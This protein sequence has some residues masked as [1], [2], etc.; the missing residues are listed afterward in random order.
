MIKT[1]KTT[2]KPAKVSKPQVQ[3]TPKPKVSSKKTTPLKDVAKIV[4]KTGVSSAQT[5]TQKK[6]E[7][8]LATVTKTIAPVSTKVLTQ[9]VFPQIQSSYLLTFDKLTFTKSP[10]DTFKQSTTKFSPYEKLTGIS[11]ERPELVMLTQFQPVYKIG[12]Q[13]TKIDLDDDDMFLTS[14]GRFFEAQM[15]LRYLRDQNV[16]K[17]LSD[18]KKTKSAQGEFL[19]RAAKFRDAISDLSKST[20]QLLSVVTRLEAV[21]QQLDLRHDIHVVSPD[22]LKALQ[23]DNYVG[24]SDLYANTKQESISQRFDINDILS[25][26]GF[27]KSNVLD[28][29]SSTKLW[30]QLLYEFKQICRSHSLSLID[31]D[32]ASYKNDKSPV[33]LVKPTTG[34]FSVNPQVGIFDIETL[35]NVEP[36]QVNIAID[37][38]DTVY[39]SL[40]N[41]VKLKTPEIRI[42]M[43]SWILSKEYRFSHAFEQSAVT[44]ALSSYYR[45]TINTTNAGNQQMLD[46]VIGQFGDDI[47]DIS[48]GSG[49]SLVD[50]SQAKPNENTAVLTFEE[51]YVVGENGTI[52]PGSVYYV[53]SA[54]NVNDLSLTT[55]RL[56]ALA[57]R[58]ENAYK[59]WSVMSSGMN[60]LMK[61][62]TLR[63]GPSHGML[64]NPR[65]LYVDIASKVIDF[66]SG[67]VQKQAASDKMSAVFATAASAKGNRLKAA[68]FSLIMCRLAKSYGESGFQRFT[69]AVRTIQNSLSGTSDNTP[70]IDRI[71]DE[72][73]RTLE[74][75]IQTSV[76]SVSSYVSSL[77]PVLGSR[78]SQVDVDQSL[79]EESLRSALKKGSY[80]LDAAEDIMSKI[81][82]T[83]ENEA[84]LDG[85]SRFSGYQDTIVMMIAF[86]LVVNIFGKYSSK[87]FVG[88]YTTF[89]STTFLIDKTNPRFTQSINDIEGRLD[90]EIQLTQQSSYAVL[91]TLKRLSD[92]VRSTVTFLESPST[93]GTIGAISKILN[94]E[95][96][97]NML[98]NR[99]QLLVLANTVGDMLLNLQYA[100][101]ERGTKD[102]I[103]LDVDNDN[104]TDYQDE[105]RI[106]DDGVVSPRTKRAIEGLLKTPEFATYKAFN[107]KIL[108]VGI[109]LGFT[110][111]L[112]QS[113]TVSKA[114]RT[115]FTDKQEDIVN[116]CVY[117]VDLENPDIIYKPRKF[118]FEMSRF[119]VRVDELHPTFNDS[120]A[121][122]VDRFPTRDYTQMF[123]SAGSPIQYLVP[124]RSEVGA[125]ADDSYNF[126]S[127]DM[128]RKIIHNHVVSFLLETYV[129]VMTG[130]S[131]SE[132]S[133]EMIEARKFVDE[134]FAEMLAALQLSET[135]NRAKNKAD[136]SGPVQTKEGRFFSAPVKVTATRAASVGKQT[137]TQVKIEPKQGMKKP[138]DHA[139][140]VADVSTSKKDDRS[141]RVV[142][143]RTSVD[144][145][146]LPTVDT[147]I[148][149]VT[150]GSLPVVLQQFKTL[151]EFTRMVTPLANG[152][153]VSKKMLSPKQFDRVFTIVVDPDDFEIDYDETMS[154]PQGRDAL[155]QLISLG[156]V[157][158][159][160][161]NDIAQQRRSTTKIMS[162]ANRS[163]KE[164]TYK[165]RDRNKTSGDAVFEKYFVVIETLG[166]ET[167]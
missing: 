5:K 15:Q 61:F 145:E 42:A 119:P 67:Y 150:D 132:H 91:N 50:V 28:Y 86:D 22:E 76:T 35:G 115:S 148:Q 19:L 149:R 100:S 125:F 30:L 162:I 64:S 137:S 3:P 10:I 118:P 109:P 123:E 87:T 71:I 32:V 139:Y 17:M 83:F 152:L 73:F 58:L 46:A 159:A 157:V 122:Y 45:Y 9:K 40:Y 56:N 2:K 142:T 85:R 158:H 69:N 156:D 88:R 146:K 121:D 78:P 59:N 34:R 62:D 49:N 133:F 98:M 33:Y 23:I 77:I 57:T 54:L 60:L 90:V 25:R 53:D 26:F 160:T 102:V 105:I 89:N 144:R 11:K 106:L 113:V 18:V 41:N 161:D 129:H 112:R 24:K 147:E 108:S 51:K 114:T 43:L 140:A 99:Q 151:D 167:I 124:G 96:L 38:I 141:T 16:Y 127:D 13:G 97:V 92:S 163:T 143:A 68:L 164:N 7:T 12:E 136:Q 79:S 128:K 52:T 8:A 111:K 165:F 107:K 39:K 6:V 95:D 55:N 36:E 116:V 14:A 44:N 48:A 117:K 131:V 130:L 4:T 80:L 29:Y 1:L 75:S 93:I 27:E 65:E 101:G 155:N 82:S 134:D 66:T 120:L 84:F 110:E 31:A 47:A 37:S 135:N 21:K 138:S 81:M 153:E 74:S 126:L 20:N 63:S 166:S 154:T 103:S 94:D 104:D 72:V 70:T